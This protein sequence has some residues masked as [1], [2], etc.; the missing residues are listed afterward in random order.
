[1]AQ[2]HLPVGAPGEE[3]RLPVQRSPEQGTLTLRPAGTAL[4][5]FE[6]PKRDEDEIDLLAY[7]QI[8]LKRRRLVLGILASILALA[9]LVTLLSPAVYRA[10]TTLQIDRE[11]MQI[12]QVEGMAPQEAANS[13]DFYQTQ[14]ELLQSRSLAERVADSLNLTDSTVVDRVMNHSWIDRLTTGL[15]PKTQEEA[16][17]KARETL[18]SKYALRDAAKA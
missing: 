6:E 11:A 9:L 2:D 12:V 7:W 8:L 4:D 16:A 3:P 17:A 1:M 15:R 5:L 13:G 18:N 14:Y 10:T